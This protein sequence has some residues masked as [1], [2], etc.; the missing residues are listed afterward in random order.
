MLPDLTAAQLASL[1]TKEKEQSDAL[2]IAA[3]QEIA[4]EVF[5]GSQTKVI[6]TAYK[7]VPPI[8][9]AREAYDFYIKDRLMTLGA[10]QQFKNR[11]ELRVLLGIDAEAKPLNELFAKLTTNDNERNKFFN[12]LYRDLKDGTSD[13][14]TEFVHI[15]HGLFFDPQKYEQSLADALED[16][17]INY[18][19]S[20]R[21]A[22][23]GTAAT[24]V[25]SDGLVQ[26]IF[27]TI[28][29]DVK[30]ELDRMPIVLEGEEKTFALSQDYVLLLAK[31]ISCLRLNLQ[32]LRFDGLV[33]NAA[34]LRALSAGNPVEQL[35]LYPILELLQT[36]DVSYLD[37][38][39]LT[40]AANGQLVFSDET[41]KSVFEQ[42]DAIDA[43]LKDRI[44][45][46][47][48]ESSTVDIYEFLNEA[49]P[50]AAD[51]KQLADILSLLQKAVGAKPAIKAI[52]DELKKLD[53][54]PEIIVAKFK[55]L[56]GHNDLAFE[57]AVRKLIDAH[58]QAKSV[59]IKGI[60]ILQAAKA[61]YEKTKKTVDAFVF[62]LLIKKRAEV[63]DKGKFDT[64]MSKFKSLKRTPDDVA[65]IF[66]YDLAVGQAT[67]KYATKDDF[68][69]WFAP[70]GLLL[71]VIKDAPETAKEVAAQGPRAQCNVLLDSVKAMNAGVMGSS[72]YA[73]PLTLNKELVLAGIYKGKLN[74]LIKSLEDYYI[75]KIVFDVT[76]IVKAAG[77]GLED[78]DEF[79]VRM[80]DMRKFLV[81][82]FFA[83]VLAQLINLNEG[84][85]EAPIPGLELT[86]TAAARNATL[87]HLLKDAFTPFIDWLKPKGIPRDMGG[88]S[89]LRWEDFVAAR[90][91]VM[92]H[93]QDAL[94]S[95]AMKKAYLKKTLDAAEKKEMSDAFHRYFNYLFSHDETVVDAKP[96]ITEAGILKYIQAGAARILSGKPATPVKAPEPTKSSAPTVAPP[97]PPAPPRT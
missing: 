5:T 14:I 80:V 50:N 94:N 27:E 20:Q 57:S 1:Q 39:K 68:R 30:A 75:G 46:I 73:K 63:S 78:S 4:N 59:A 44:M 84:T 8:T 42:K 67:S 82:V 97:R 58:L 34:R 70:Y 89:T 83:E 11:E 91:K 72:V 61:E 65:R 92:A 19:M 79:E 21:P 87:Y 81:T 15:V 74:D 18:A 35:R 41:L 2:V 85:G 77:L 29:H 22:V 55:E 62:D 48:K 9:N 69:R 33:G 36:H 53:P 95:A 45:R 10:N 49:I 56:T 28:I 25:I 26:E 32:F 40:F 13:L 17:I 24:R 93:I 47:L 7:K 96:K 16:I 6:P 64:A 38:K 12:N 71:E 51:T 52:Q 23:S 31:R 54:N 86:G 37:R 90:D 43:M 76:A 66:S 3:F 88:L 60:E